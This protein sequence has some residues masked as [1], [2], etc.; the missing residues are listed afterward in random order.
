M[1]GNRDLG[2]S[3]LEAIHALG[4]ED[5]PLERLCAHTSL[6]PREVL[7]G[8]LMLSDRGLIRFS[9]VEVCAAESELSVARALLRP[10]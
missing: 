10:R 6:P 8:L 3:V 1:D 9:R 7:A 4:D 5:V 2:E